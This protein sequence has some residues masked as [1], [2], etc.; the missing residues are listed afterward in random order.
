MKK[1]TSLQGRQDFRH[2][3]TGSSLLLALL[4]CIPLCTEG[5]RLTAQQQPVSAL[6]AEC[7]HVP[8]GDCIPK[9][10]L[11]Q[12]QWV[13]PAASSIIVL[14]LRAQDT[15]YQSARDSSSPGTWILLELHVK[16]ALSHC[17]YLKA[18]WQRDELGDQ[19]I[20]PHHRGVIKL[21]PNK[22][23]RTWHLTWLLICL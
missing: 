6:K 21:C 22:T 23:A 9:Y 20:S 5:R 8:V 1:S 3:L 11:A 2:C 10:S 15:L 14:L 19:S 18:I 12:D 13:V 16:V 17:V 4:W 7:C